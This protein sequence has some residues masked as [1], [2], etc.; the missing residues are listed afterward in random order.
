MIDK[1]KILEKYA[2]DESE[3]NDG[4]V[5]F[6][7]TELPVE[8]LPIAHKMDEV[9][10][11]EIVSGALY[12]LNEGYRSLTDFFGSSSNFGRAYIK[13][14]EEVDKFVEEL[15]EIYRELEMDFEDL[16]NSLSP[17]NFDIPYLACFGETPIEWGIPELT[18]EE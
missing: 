6:N 15:E 9:G 10:D 8:Y 16:S 1:N 2:D 13:N 5:E 4:K 11:Q 12:K 18:K 7:G 14:R 17:L 3:V